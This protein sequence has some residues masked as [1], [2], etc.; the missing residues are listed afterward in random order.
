MREDTQHAPSDTIFI[1][2]VYKITPDRIDA[3]P[4]TSFVERGIKE[5]ADLQRLL[6]VNIGVVTNP[7]NPSAPGVLVIAEEFGEW[8]DSKRRIDLLGVDDKG[9]LVVIE[10]KRNDDGSHMELQAIRYA[11]MVSRMTFARAVEVYQS[12]LDKHAPGHDARGKL[13]EFLHWEEPREEEFAADVRIVLVSAEFK[14]EI[15]TAVLWLNERDLDIR[16]VRVMPY[17]NGTETIVDVQQIIPQPDIAE[18]LIQIKQKERAVRESVRQGGVDTGYWFMNTGDGSNEGRSWEDC[19]KYGFMLAGGG[20]KW[21]DDAK[22]LKV[23]D[24]LF[25]YLSGH[26][27]VGLGTVTAEAVP[28]KDFVPRGQGK[29]LPDLPLSAKLQRERMADPECWDL[30]AAVDWV[31]AVPRSGGV[32][33]N[34]ARNGTLNRIKQPDLV[35]E[36]LRVFDPQNAPT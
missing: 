34:R 21:I 33:M 6:R 31:K 30:C 28:F 17:A 12:H 3:L 9:N 13:L 23:G 32:L 16:C 36:L 10:L 24:K 5:R 27:Y 29:P 18:R 25:A 35:A 22:K 2:P 8:D 15:T 1:M 26:G 4:A 20:K 14:K 11:A 7:E 19:M